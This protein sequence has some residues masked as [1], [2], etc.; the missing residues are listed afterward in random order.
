MRLRHPVKG[1]QGGVAR[2]AYSDSG[3]TLVELVI[4]I[5]VLGIM[6][7]VAI[8]VVGTFIATSK[9]TAT[10]DELRVLA[11]AIAGSDEFTDRGFEGDVGFPPS[12][13]SDLITKPDS[14]SAWDAFADIGWNGPYLDGTGGEYLRDAWDSNYVYDPA[15]RTIVSVGS[16]SS[17]TVNF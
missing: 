17:I 13:L 10:K 7:A 6:S 4:V 1:R 8:P 9:E 12:S 14:I 11:R 16:G 2:F 3:F 15:A 5:A